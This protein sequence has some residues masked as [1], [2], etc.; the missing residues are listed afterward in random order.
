MKPFVG[1]HLSA[2]KESFNCYLSSARV[3][4]EN[5]FGKLKARWRILH[6]IEANIDFAPFIIGSCCILHNICEQ[7]NT[8]HIPISDQSQTAGSNNA[9]QQ[10]NSRDSVSAAAEG[11]RHR[12]A[13]LKHITRQ[14]P[15]RQVLRC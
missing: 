5:A 15:T 1:S 9:A 2:D 4:V 14:L 10:P 7:T 13:I 12:E 6:H 11:V 3:F 8:P